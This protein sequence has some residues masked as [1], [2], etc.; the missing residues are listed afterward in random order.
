MR[1]FSRLIA[2]HSQHRVLRVPQSQQSWQVEAGI[3]L[4]RGRYR[5]AQA[6]AKR[7]D[8]IAFAKAATVGGLYA[9]YGAHSERGVRPYWLLK[10][11]L[12]K[13]AYQL[14][15]KAAVEGG[16]TLRMDSWVVDAQCICAWYHST[17]DA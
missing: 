10:V 16:T 3:R 5:K 9:S 14:K 1:M 13:V 8:A 12:K 17:S 11:K 15:R 6:T 2:F 7:G 4:R